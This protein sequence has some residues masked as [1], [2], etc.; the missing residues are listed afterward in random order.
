MR[1]WLVLPL[2]ASLGLVVYACD[3]KLTN[4]D[5]ADASVDSPVAPT[6]TTTAPLPDGGLPDNYVPAPDSGPQAGPVTAL[7]T[8]DV[9]APSAGTD[10]YFMDPDGTVTKVATGA[11]GKATHT[12]F[13]GGSLTA[14]YVVNGMI[15]PPTYYLTTVVELT[16]GDTIHIA[17][18][19]YVPFVAAGQITGTLANAPTLDAGGI[20]YG[21][22]PFCSG[23][24]IVP[25]PFPQAY[26]FDLDSTCIEPSTGKVPFI[27]T[28]R[29]L[30]NSSLLAYAALA[31]ANPDGGVGNANVAAGDW[32]A[33]PHKQ[34]TFTGAVA[35]GF[36]NVN[37]D[38][39]TPR[40]GQLHLQA[41]TASATAI[42]QPLDYVTP[43][44]AFASVVQSHTVLTG[45]AVGDILTSTRY[46]RIPAANP[47]SEDF[48]K[49]LPR[50]HDFKLAGTTAAPS[51]QWQNDSA[52][53]AD[54]FATVPLS[55]TH[56]PDGG[57]GSSVFWSVVFPV[58]AATTS[59]TAPTLPP[60]LL[61]Q[62]APDN[63]WYGNQ[64][65]IG[66]SAQ[67]PYILAHQYPTVLI[68]PQIFAAQIPANLTFDVKTTGVCSNCD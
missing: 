35:S 28:A 34:M 27:A 67:A 16:P 11:D 42:T 13:A 20:S 54:A 36:T 43:P 32:L 55:G 60:A 39:A 7:V 26:T 12:M 5:A 45:Y 59:F 47:L 40:N 21:F 44:A 33:A 56:T 19:I 38:I 31:V 64:I 3:D 23:W 49:L 57:Q 63:A 66:A 8:N 10:V 14:N 65:V 68:N 25:G 61:A 2:W 46:Q 41:S 4:N 1:K 18:N 9:G 6:S 15:A 51:V 24:N 52:L 22:E 17:R 53:P 30:Q 37:V 62:M 58:H 29:D 50:V 48:T